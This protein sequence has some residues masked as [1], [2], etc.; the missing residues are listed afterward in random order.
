MSAICAAV[1]MPRTPVAT[2]LVPS[3]TTRRGRSGIPESPDSTNVGENQEPNIC[4]SIGLS[5]IQDMSDGA[6]DLTCACDGSA[7][8]AAFSSGSDACF[9]A[10]SSA[11]SVDTVVL[12]SSHNSMA[13]HRQHSKHI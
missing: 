8:P 12:M 5:H 2:R 1:V 6:A 3:H 11:N 7:K 13:P 10:R 9:L 4:A